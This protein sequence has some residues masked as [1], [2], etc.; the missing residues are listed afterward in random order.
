MIHTKNFIRSFKGVK[1]LMEA[2]EKISPRGRENKRV[3]PKI[4][5][6]TR[7]PS[8]SFDVTERNTLISINT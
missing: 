3:R 5:T 1:R 4:L 7:N 8:R 2:K 6:V